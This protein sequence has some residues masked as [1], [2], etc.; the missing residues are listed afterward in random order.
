MVSNEVGLVTDSKDA[1]SGTKGTDEDCL[2]YAIVL[3]TNIEDLAVFRKWTKDA[4]TA[5]SSTEV[6]CQMVSNRCLKIREHGKCD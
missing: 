3:K 6:I 4:L 5:L 1:K 2:T